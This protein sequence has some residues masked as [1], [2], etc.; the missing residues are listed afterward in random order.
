MAREDAAWELEGAP[1]PP[2][3]MQGEA[4]ALVGPGLGFRAD[5]QIVTCR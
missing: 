1:T 2:K 4:G 3:G 5:T